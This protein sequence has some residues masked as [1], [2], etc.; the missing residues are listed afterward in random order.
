[1]CLEL[2]LEHDYRG[3]LH[4]C[5]DGVC[6]RVE[7]AERVAQRF[8]LT[9]RIEP[10]LTAAVKLPAPRPLRG[11]LIVAR[12]AA[13]L[14]NKPL[15]LDAALDRFYEEWQRRGG[16]TAG[17]GEFAVPHWPFP[18]RG[19]GGSTGRLRAA[20]LAPGPLSPEERRPTGWLKRAAALALLTLRR[21]RGTQPASGPNTFTLSQP[22]GERAG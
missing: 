18:R 5:D 15:S 11:G 7:F 4:T 13:L 19:E 22:L 14:K 8:G 1:M 3:V 9:G 2:L 20:A 17:R 6:T 12:A 16:T 21:E 10:V